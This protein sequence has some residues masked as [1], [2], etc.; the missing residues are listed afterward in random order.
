MKHLLQDLAA[1]VVG[2]LFVLMCWCLLIFTFGLVARANYELFMFG[3]ELI[4]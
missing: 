1:W 3:W 4:K 2:T